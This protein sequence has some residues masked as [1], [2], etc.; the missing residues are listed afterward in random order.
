M[1]RRARCYTRLSRGCPHNASCGSWQLRPERQFL[2]LKQ[3]NRRAGFIASKKRE[4]SILNKTSPA[5]KSLLAHP[6]P[7]CRHTLH[8]P[9]SPSQQ[10]PPRRP[11]GFPSNRWELR[12]AGASPAALPAR[13]RRARGCPAGQGWG[14][15]PPQPYGA[16]WARSCP[17]PAAGR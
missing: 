14:M 4:K 13:R 15:R 12:G 3:I 5:H 10:P 11:R 6:R 1:A 2:F 8:L 17:R 16:R 7:G 9:L